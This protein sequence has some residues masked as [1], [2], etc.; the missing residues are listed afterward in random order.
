MSEPRPLS[1]SL[2]DAR[3]RLMRAVDS[4]GDELDPDLMEVRARGM[5]EIMEA[6][7]HATM[8]QRFAGAT[9][10][11]ISDPVAAEKLRVWSELTRQPNLVVLG[12]VGTGKTSAAV[13]ALRRAFDACLEV[14]FAPA[15]VLL[16]SL[17]PKGEACLDD[18]CQADRLLIDDVGQETKTPWTTEQL[19]LIITER[20]NEMR[21]TVVTSNFKAKDLEAHLGVHTASRL[22][23]DGA[24]VIVMRGPDRRR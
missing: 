2:P 18:Y 3:R 24:E 7:W 16:N 17:P 12:P 20:Y 23:G 1:I 4:I 14:R 21:P 19:G 8:T 5:A 6:R 15:G 10:E 13:V 9:W 22:M 11:G